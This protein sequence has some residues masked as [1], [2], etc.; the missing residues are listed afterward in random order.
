MKFKRKKLF[1]L[2]SKRHGGKEPPNDSWMVAARAVND[3]GLE[4][5]PEYVLEYVLGLR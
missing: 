1:F 4:S 2:F 5:A 3:S